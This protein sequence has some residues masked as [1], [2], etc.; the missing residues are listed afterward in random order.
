[1]LVDY[2]LHLEE[3]PYNLSWL[4]KTAESLALMNK[5]ITPNSSRTEMEKTVSLLHE[6]VQNGA[7]TEAWLDLYLQQALALG[8]KEVGIVDHLYR[9][10][11]TTA[12]FEKHMQLDV[13]T[14][15]GRL[16]RHWLDSVVTDNMADFFNCITNAKEKWAAHGVTLKVGIE[17]DYFIGGE[18]ELAALITLHEW[19]YVIGSVHFVDGWGFDNPQLISIFDDYDLK[20]LYDQFFTVVLSMIES[21]LFDFVAH[22][23]NLKIFNYRIE[24]ELFMLAWYERIARALKVADIATEVNAGLH[25]RY[26]VKESCPAPA[27]LAILAD[28]NIPLTISSDAHYPHHLGM[29]VREHA[30]TLKQL[31]VI[32][33][34]TFTN[35]KRE[36]KPL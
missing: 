18:E 10:H 27:F 8:I 33:I 29:L 23:D 2:H 16:Q 19:D 17:C 1:M 11:E 5:Q 15:L 30:A 32:E 31:N 35:R 28:Y 34:A 9:F 6:R 20:Q 3:G 14:E 4:S 22:L 12:Y 26:P 7:F 21:K 24:D 13:T 36:M 25:Y